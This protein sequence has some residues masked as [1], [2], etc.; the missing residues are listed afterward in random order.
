M[1]RAHKNDIVDDLANGYEQILEKSLGDFFRAERKTER[2]LH[3]LVQ[4][5]K[6]KIVDAKEISKKD[7]ELIAEY[8]T[9]D[10]NHLS[11]YIADTRNE[12]KDW[13][14]FEAVLLESEMLDLLVKVADSA[15]VDLI[16][17]NQAA[18]RSNTEYAV[19]EIAGPGTFK[20]DDCENTVAF[21]AATEIVPCTNCAGNKFT[22]V[23]V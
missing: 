7:A 18:E 17:L 16:L 6:D 23:T 1:N 5:A 9:R 12:L 14:G 10:V 13:L 15:T 22:R 4:K 19:G 21:H 20:C 11:T 2:S 3:H 8:V